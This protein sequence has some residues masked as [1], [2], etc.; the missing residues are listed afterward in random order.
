VIILAPTCYGLNAVMAGTVTRIEVRG[1]VANLKWQLFDL[2]PGFCV[3]VDQRRAEVIHDPIVEKELDATVPAL[4][5]AGMSR[6]C[7]IAANGDV[8]NAAQYIARKVGLGETYF[9]IDGQN[10]KADQIAE[11]WIADGRRLVGI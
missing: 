6:I 3:L 7:V 8:A 9:C 10:P 5:T 1:M 11:A 4:R 2:N